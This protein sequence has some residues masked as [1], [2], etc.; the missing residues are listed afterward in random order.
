MSADEL[1]LFPQD[2]RT[3]RRPGETVELSGMWAL[4]HR[5]KAVEARLL[6]FT[7][8]RGIEDIVVVASQA[9]PSPAEAGE[10]V[11]KFTLPEGPYSC[12]GRLVSIK[13]AVELV[14]DAEAARW[15]FTLG[16]DGR[17]IALGSGGGR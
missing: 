14:A 16:P 12:S 15:E 10:Q 2:E 17:E 3:G 4:G 9:V 1:D 8:G 6:W 11:F 7:R 5:P 13:W